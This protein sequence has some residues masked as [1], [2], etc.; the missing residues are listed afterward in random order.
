MA[1][2]ILLDDNRL[3]PGQTLK[4]SVI[5]SFES[6]PSKLALQLLWQTSGK[7]T[8]DSETIHSEDWEPNANTGSKIFE[9]PLPRGPI[10]VRGK[11]I[12]IGWQI[13][14]SSKRPQANCVLPF[15]LSHQDSL[16]RL[17]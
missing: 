12:S 1:I 3:K 14:C 11:L 5:W 17:F 13:E 9:I 10:S 6:T 15:V 2:Q 16:V 8:E 7:G 4:G